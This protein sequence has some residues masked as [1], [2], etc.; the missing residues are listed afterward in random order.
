MNFRSLEEFW[1]FYVTQHSNPSTRRWH[2]MGTLMSIVALVSSILFSRWLLI[3][4]PVSGYGFA[5]YSHFFVE[6]NLP[7][8]F[9]HPI[10]SLLCDLKMFGLML[11]GSMER[12]MKRLGKRPL[13]ATRA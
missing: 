5:W 1:G 2:F 4:V 3:M 10:W 12:E 13:T 7:A 9:G 8:S 11:T 6:G